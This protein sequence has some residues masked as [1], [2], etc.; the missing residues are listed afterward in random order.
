MTRSRAS[1]LAASDGWQR[2]TDYHAQVRWDNQPPKAERRLVE[3]KL[4]DGLI[5]K[6]TRVLK[7]KKWQEDG[8]TQLFE[9][10]T[11]DGVDTYQT[12]DELML[13]GLEAQRR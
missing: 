6:V 4:P 10:Q 12:F 5:A 9:L 8:G 13:Q 2:L 7:G 3:I 1:M 11:D